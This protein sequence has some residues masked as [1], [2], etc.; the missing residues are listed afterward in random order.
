MTAN[1]QLSFPGKI[2][3]QAAKLRKMVKI[4]IPNEQNKEKQKYIFTKNTFYNLLWKN[5]N[6][7]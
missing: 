7:N 5:P 4:H 1:L 6:T 2:H 3:L